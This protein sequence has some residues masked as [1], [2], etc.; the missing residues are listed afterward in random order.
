MAL[1]ENTSFGRCVQPR[2][3][4][5]GAAPP[6]PDDCIRG[7]VMP[8]SPCPSDACM[9]MASQAPRF[10]PPLTSQAPTHHAASHFPSPL[11]PTPGD[12]MQL[13]SQAP[14]CSPLFTYSVESECV[15]AGGKSVMRSAWG[16]VVSTHVHRGL[17][18]RGRGDYYA[19]ESCGF[20]LHAANL[21]SGRDSEFRWEEPGLEWGWMMG[22]VAGAAGDEGEDGREGGADGAEGAD[23]KDV[24]SARGGVGGSGRGRE[25]PPSS[26]PQAYMLHCLPPGS[27]A[28]HPELDAGWQ[29]EE[30]ARRDKG[31]GRGGSGLGGKE[32]R[33]IGAMYAGRRYKPGSKEPEWPRWC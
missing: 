15:P 14:E 33:R 19:E 7:F 25:R 30:A 10:S 22:E 26:E 16:A 28:E 1:Q 23:V 24:D 21:W 11:P 9:Q 2:P 29:E 18:G 17:V 27:L 8:A 4:S 3:L 12:R 31:R 20:V 32:L 5:P 13:A 6:P